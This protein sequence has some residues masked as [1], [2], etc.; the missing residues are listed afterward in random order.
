MGAVVSVTVSRPRSG[1]LN[2][3]LVV[4]LHAAVLGLGCEGPNQTDPEPQPDPPPSSGS[5]EPSSKPLAPQAPYEGVLASP[6]AKWVDVVDAQVFSVEVPELLEHRSPGHWSTEDGQASLTVT[7][8]NLEE[9]SA[10]ERNDAVWNATPSRERYSKDSERAVSTQHATYWLQKVPDSS[11]AL[12]CK[13]E[14][15][16]DQGTA[17]SRQQLMRAICQTTRYED[18]DTPRGRVTPVRSEPAE[19]TEWWNESPIRTTAKVDNRSF[20][21]AVPPGLTVRSSRH[22]ERGSPD[23]QAF[24]GVYAVSLEEGDVPTRLEAL[25]ALHTRIGERVM[26]DEPTTDGHLLVH[27]GSVNRFVRTPDAKVAL[28]CQAGIKGPVEDENARRESLV[29]I[30]RSLRLATP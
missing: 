29:E 10:S 3:L 15:R 28:Q 30:C 4:G 13:V 17:R 2:V 25:R 5:T 1:R 7:L 24:V 19:T 12:W 14:D 16:G 23:H 6:R 9:Q 18:A 26:I 20:S 21:I 8:V 27:A 22:F 11:N